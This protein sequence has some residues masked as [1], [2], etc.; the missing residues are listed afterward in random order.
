MRA[1][2]VQAR[3][4]FGSYRAQFG[5]TSIPCAIL[6]R[7]S[8][9]KNKSLEV[10]VVCF[11]IAFS[12]ANRGRIRKLYFKRVNDCVRDLVFKLEHIPHFVLDRV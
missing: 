12:R 1:M 9:L 6:P 4:I 10:K 8:C 7:R 5:N 2:P 3:L 11:G